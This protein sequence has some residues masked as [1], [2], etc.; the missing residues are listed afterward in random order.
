[1][2]RNYNNSF[3]VPM[4]PQ[5]IGIVQ[6]YVPLSRDQAFGNINETQLQILADTINVMVGGGLNA[7]QIGGD[8]DNTIITIDGKTCLVERWENVNG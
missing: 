5:H 1:M 6:T 2:W 7:G 4:M 8:G 3:N